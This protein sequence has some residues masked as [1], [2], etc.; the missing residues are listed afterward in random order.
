MSGLRDHKKSLTHHSTILKLIEVVDIKEVC[1]PGSPAGAHHRVSRVVGA[2]GE[3]LEE[4]GAEAN[5]HG[6]DAR[7]A[8]VAVEVEHGDVQAA[9]HL[10]QLLEGE[11]TQ[12]AAAQHK[13]GV[14]AWV[15]IQNGSEPKGV[16]E[17]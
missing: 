10:L 13:E 7:D 5:D 3:K 2:P 14:N 15:A 9:M 17:L 1:P 16:L 12:E 4:G 11:V 6:V 8:D